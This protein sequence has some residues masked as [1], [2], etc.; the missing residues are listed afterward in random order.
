MGFLVVG[1]V[2]D[3]F[4]GFVV[5]FVFVGFFFG[6][7]FSVCRERGLVSEGFFILFVL[8]GFFFRVDSVVLD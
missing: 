8:I 7:D 1:E 6:V 2:F 3:A 5:R 4:E